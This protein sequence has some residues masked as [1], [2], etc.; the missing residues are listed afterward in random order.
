[1]SAQPSKNTKATKANVA[2]AA[3]DEYA[4]VTLSDA[5]TWEE[6]DSDDSD[7][8]AAFIHDHICFIVVS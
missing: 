4:D 2:F 5:T 8:L 1:M 6:T 7:D 3:N